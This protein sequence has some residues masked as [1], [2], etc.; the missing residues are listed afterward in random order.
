MLQKKTMREVLGVLVALRAAEAEADARGRWKLRHGVG[1]P[2]VA[3]VAAVAVG[4][5]ALVG[6]RGGL[7]LGTDALGRERRRPEGNVRRRR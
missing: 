2:A 1:H 5:E 3:A 6:G 7:A 4:V